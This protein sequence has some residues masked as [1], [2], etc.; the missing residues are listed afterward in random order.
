[1]QEGVLTVMFT[2]VEGSTDVTRRLGDVEGRRVI[3]AYKTLVREELERHDGR[4][5][6]SVGDGFFITFTSP[7]GAVACAVAIQKTLLEQE[8]KDSK[9]HVRVRIGL[10]VGEV[11]ERDG[12]PFGA[13]VNATE[14]VASHAKGGQILVSEPVRH[15][16]GTIPGVSFRSRGRFA[17]KGFSERWRLY[18]IDWERP[19]RPSPRPVAKPEEKPRWRLPAF[20]AAGIVA[21][22]VLAAVLA[23]VLTGG[24]SRLSR[25][26]VNAVGMIDPGS[27]EIVGEVHVGGRPTAIASGEG[28][29][30]VANGDDRTVSRIDPSTREEVR[31]IGTGS[32]SPSDVAAGEGSVWVPTRS[33]NEL[34]VI[35]PRTDGVEDRIPFELGAPAAVAVGGGFVW[36]AEAQ[37]G[38]V[39]RL[40]PETGDKR[41]SERVG[42]QPSSV[43]FGED[44]VWVANS[45]SKSVSRLDPETG[46]VVRQNIALDAQPTAIAAGEGAVWVASLE[47][48]SVYRIDPQSN[49]SVQTIEVGNAPVGIAAG[50][51]SVWVA[52][53]LDRSVWRID[54]RTNR[55]DRK[56]PVG[57]SPD[58][59]VV[60]SGRVWVTAHAP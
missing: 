15:L 43:A 11:I 59:V 10:N 29:L 58:G 52:N 55:V 13:A 1:V 40:A 18:E 56:I 50:E 36:I 39:T 26:D 42:T 45:H 35:S 28:A 30:W 37:R 27:G 57:N 12:H 22:G 8:R 3:E 16:A 6:D 5:I 9:E 54:P 38:R 44:G 25:I 14:R 41:L 51:G 32:T 31:A 33:G 49:R 47:A 21:A 7:R 60:A 2:D 48:D 19:E 24:D 46:R 23:L 4:E 53:S 17:V 34:V 20:V